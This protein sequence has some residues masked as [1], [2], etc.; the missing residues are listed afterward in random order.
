[1]LLVQWSLACWCCHLKVLLAEL[2]EAEPPMIVLD[3]HLRG[4][5]CLNEL[6]HRPFS[7]V[8]SAFS[9]G[10]WQFCLFLSLRNML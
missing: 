1:V 10:E 2:H 5:C 7:W 9:N 4:V 6:E 3:L 8:W